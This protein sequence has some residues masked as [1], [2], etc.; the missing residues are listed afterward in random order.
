MTDIQP[1]IDALNDALERDP[2][3]LN[4][5]LSRFAPCNQELIDHPTVQVRAGSDNHA[6]VGV[7]G[8]LNGVLE[9]LTGDRVAAVYLD[10]NM[11]ITCFKKYSECNKK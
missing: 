3:A 11:E 7:L 9:P 10:E 8:L 1:A 2:K 6:I 5:L 4:Y